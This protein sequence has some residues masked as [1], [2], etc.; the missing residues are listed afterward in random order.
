MSEKSN[1]FLESKTYFSTTTED[2]LET[3]TIS[4]DV[5]YY[6]LEVS[7]TSRV[8]ANNPFAYTPVA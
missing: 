5:E 1:L 3:M 2:L 7:A 6:S 4:L 8:C